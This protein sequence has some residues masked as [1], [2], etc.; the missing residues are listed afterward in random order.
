M[1]ALQLKCV[2]RIMPDG[3]VEACHDVGVDDGSLIV[4]CPGLEEVLT[5]GSQVEPLLFSTDLARSEAETHGRWRVDL[6][7]L[8]DEW[9]SFGLVLQQ[10]AQ[11]SESFGGLFR[12]GAP[13]HELEQVIGDQ[14]LLINQAT[15]ASPEL[16]ERLKWSRIILSVEKTVEMPALWSVGRTALRAAARLGHEHIARWLLSNDS[17]EFSGTDLLQ[18]LGEAIDGAHVATCKLYFAAAVQRGVDVNADGCGVNQPLAYSH[19]HGHEKMLGAAMIKCY[20]AQRDARERAMVIME[21]L[22][23]QEVVKLA[24]PRSQP[25]SASR[26]WLLMPH[27][28]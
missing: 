8:Y 7:G 16:H 13:V 1:E 14:H 25:W 26:V 27:G 17:A 6:L 5:E 2:G 10:C 20:L 15:S 22:V 3:S 12:Q 4:G 18:A 24:A 11:L 21:W 28:R 19:I 9:D 23:T